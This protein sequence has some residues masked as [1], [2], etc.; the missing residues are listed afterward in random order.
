MKYKIEYSIMGKKKLHTQTMDSAMG[1]ID[2]FQ[3][4]VMKHHMND[5]DFVIMYRN[6]SV[7]YYKNYNIRRKVEAEIRNEQQQTQLQ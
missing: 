4:N 1:L 6:D 2:V 7:F 5:L 3:Q